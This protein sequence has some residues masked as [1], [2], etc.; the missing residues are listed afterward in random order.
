MQLEHEEAQRQAE[1]D[2][3]IFF[4]SS[5]KETTENDTHDLLETEKDDNEEAGDDE[6]TPDFVENGNQA[7]PDLDVE[8]MRLVKP[9]PMDT[10]SLGRVSSPPLS[11]TPAD[12]IKALPNQDAASKSPSTIKQ[13]DDNPDYKTL[14]A[15]SMQLTIFRENANRIADDYLKSRGVELSKPKSRYSGVSDYSAYLQGTRRSKKI[16]IRRKRI[17]V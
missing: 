4:P 7:D 9:E 13:E 14:W 11:T 10:P 12:D 2:R 1:L 17:E 8:I 6:T 3:L 5:L 16:D 15:S